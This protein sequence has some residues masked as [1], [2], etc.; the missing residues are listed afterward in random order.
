MFEAGWTESP[1][2]LACDAM[3]WLV[4]GGGKV[5]VVFIVLFNEITCPLRRRQAEYRRLHEE[6]ALHYAS[7]E[8]DDDDDNRPVSPSPSTAS[9]HIREIENIPVADWVGEV[10]VTVS[11]W[12]YSKQ[13]GQAYKDGVE[14][15]LYPDGRSEPHGVEPPCVSVQEV[16]GGR[17]TGADAREVAFR[18]DWGMMREHVEAARRQYAFGRKQDLEKRMGVYL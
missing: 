6:Q 16:W 12:R 17:D 2:D 10:V 1:Y 4:K 18:L 7:E 11:V 14:Y 15:T 3:Q 9:D 8:V 5:K 13:W